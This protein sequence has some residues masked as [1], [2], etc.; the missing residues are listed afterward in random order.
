MRA[1]RETIEAAAAAAFAAARDLT[2][3][4]PRTPACEG[5]RVHRATPVGRNHRSAVDAA[6][7]IVKFETADVA[8][9]ARVLDAIARELEGPRA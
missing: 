2:A 5:L 1:P 6:K 9:A 8:L 7:L 3:R 4:I